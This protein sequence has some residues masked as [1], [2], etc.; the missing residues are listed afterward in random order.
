MTARFAFLSA[1]LIKTTMILGQAGPPFISDD[2]ATPGNGKWETILATT[3]ERHDTRW[4]WEVP[5]LDINYGLGDRIQLKYET[6]WLVLDD[7]GRG[8][9][10]GPGNSLLGFK[11]RFLDGGEE[12]LSMSLYPQFQ[13]NNSSHSARRGL[14]ERGSDLL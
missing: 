13:F 11:W 14:V 1:V 4:L 6:P 7:D 5:L 8:P 3:I 12:H 9:I 2:P 10:T